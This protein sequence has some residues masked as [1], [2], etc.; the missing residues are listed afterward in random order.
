MLI[1]CIC[2]LA[3]LTQTFAIIKFAFDTSRDRVHVR[4]VMES[5]V[6][7]FTIS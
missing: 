4:C 2:M 5:E 6:K 3:Y 1:M 7:S